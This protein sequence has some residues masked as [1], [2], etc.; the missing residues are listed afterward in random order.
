MQIA[1]AY[2]D[3]CH[4]SYTHGAANRSQPTLKEEI[5]M[6]FYIAETQNIQSQRAGEII[7]A[8]DLTQAKRKASAAQC[9]Q[10][11]TMK[12]YAENQ[13]TLLAVKQNGKWVNQ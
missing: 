9:F 13:T 3:N 4:Y 8:K 1:L 11:T 7:E 2:N 6:K 12:I 5:K 10:G